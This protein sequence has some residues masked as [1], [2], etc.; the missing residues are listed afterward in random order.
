MTDLPEH[1]ASDIDLSAYLDAELTLAERRRVA[2]HLA[3]C[4]RCARRLADFAALS[5]DFALL[6]MASLGTDLSGV[7][8]GRLPSAEPPRQRAARPGWRSLLPIGIGASASVALGI[9]IGA[10]LFSG[11]VAL[12]RMTAMSVFDPIPPGGLCPGLHACYARS[13][14]KTGVTQ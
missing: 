5:A 9:A 8:S 2:G 13:P 12:P 4:P 11:G 14:D 1:H 7:I 6:P 10:A 3:A